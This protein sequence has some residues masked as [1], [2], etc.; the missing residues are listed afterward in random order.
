MSGNGLSAASTCRTLLSVYSRLEPTG[1]LS[2]SEMKPSSACGTNSVPTSGTI[3]KLARNDDEGDRD[4]ALAVAER[5]L[6]DLAVERVQPFDAVLDLVHEAA[7]P[8]QR[9]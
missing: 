7:E 4:D 9:A 3:A 5:P 1:V 6:E 8:R 2:R